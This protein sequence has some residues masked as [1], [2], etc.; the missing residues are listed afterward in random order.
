MHTL[1]HVMNG[2]LLSGKLVHWLF[3]HDCCR[4]TLA[5]LSSWSLLALFLMLNN[6]QIVHCPVM[7]WVQLQSMSQVSLSIVQLPHLNI[8][9]AYTHTHTH[10]I[11]IPTV[12]YLFFAQT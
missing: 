4:D 6:S 9:S 1:E 5:V 8:Q 12:L 10:N 7:M 11:V 3:V 2:L